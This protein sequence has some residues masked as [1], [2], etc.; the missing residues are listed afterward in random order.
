[1]IHKLAGL[2]TG[3]IVAV[4]TMM[5][6]ESIGNR[7]HGSSLSADP[8][9]TL[10]VTQQPTSLLLFVLAGWFLAALVGG[11]VALRLSHTRWMAW[12]IAGAIIAGVIVMFLWTPYPFWMLIAG[13]AAPLLGAT[14]AR[15]MVKTPVA[16]ETVVEDVPAEKAD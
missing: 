8:S 12:P 2:A 13:P 14:L 5:T 10:P 6:V 16:V 7:L 9:A 15:L 11:A 4:L 1:M 3:L